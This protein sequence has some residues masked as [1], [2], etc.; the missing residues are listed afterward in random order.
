MRRIAGN[1]N[2]NI[3]HPRSNEVATVFVHTGDWFD[4]SEGIMLE[5]A[6]L[7]TVKGG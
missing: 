6:A 7:G 3:T 4:A 5:R 2:I 1:I